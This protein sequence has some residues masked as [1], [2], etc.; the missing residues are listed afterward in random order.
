MSHKNTQAFLDWTDT[1]PKQEKVYAL[2]IHE[3]LISKGIKPRMYNDVN[4]QYWYKGNRVIYL[5]KNTGRNTPLDIAIPYGLKGK[6]DDI[7][8]FVVT[9][10]GETDENKLVQYIIANI[11]CC[12]RCGNKPPKK[13]DGHWTE[14]AGVRRKLSGCNRAITK[15]KAPKAKLKYTDDDLYWLKRLIDIKIKQ[16]LQFN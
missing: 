4:F 14:F 12:N 2:T 11:C 8:S 15:Q 6:V 10:M 5:R 1:L 13:C 7:H 9:C 16:I 3:Y